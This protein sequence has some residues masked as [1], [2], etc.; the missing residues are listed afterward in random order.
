M[1]K[2]F[3]LD[4]F[5]IPTQH[6]YGMLSGFGLKNT[7]EAENRLAFMFVDCLKNKDLSFEVEREDDEEVRVLLSNGLLARVSENKYRLT[8][9]ALEKLYTC[10]AK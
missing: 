8:K 3:K 2:E 10:Y 7:N 1:N 5:K 9:L 4:D 6:P